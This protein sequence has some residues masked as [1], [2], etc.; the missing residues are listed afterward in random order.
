MF[1]GS[2]YPRER[3]AQVIG[4]VFPFQI[5]SNASAATIAGLVFDATSSY[6]PVFI[7][8]SIFSLVG[9]FFTFMARRP[10]IPV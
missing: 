2:Y 10:R 1:V 3:Y 7:A 6:T 5:I 4:V 8:A 9:V